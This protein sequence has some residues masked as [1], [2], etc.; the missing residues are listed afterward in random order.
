MD[1]Q[2]II[3]QT[4]DVGVQIGV[5]R[6]FPIT[7]ER[8]WEIVTSYKYLSLWL[9]K[10]PKVTLEPKT[11]YVTE[12]SEG[13]IRVVKPLQQLRLTWKR[14]DWEHPSTIQVRTMAKDI[15][16]TTISFHQEKMISKETR[17]KMKIYWKRILDSI[18]EDLNNE[19]I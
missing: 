9:G 13:E 6:T 3:G 18:E 19:S 7:Q 17:E 10:K 12:T 2:R 1:E 15:N 11:K 5:R 16:K 4:K 8:A 14:I